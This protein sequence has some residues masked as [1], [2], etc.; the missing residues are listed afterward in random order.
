LL[1]VV[2]PAC[3]EEVDVAVSGGAI[4]IAAAITRIVFRGAKGSM[5]GG[6]PS[7]IP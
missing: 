2:T 3:K 1:P 7:A 4:Q 6:V 5:R